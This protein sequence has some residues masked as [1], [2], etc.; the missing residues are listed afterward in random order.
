MDARVFKTKTFARWLRKSGVSDEDLLKA[1]DD[2]EK[3]LVDADL[4]GSVYKK[5]IGINSRGKRGGARTIVATRFESRWFFMFG[6]AKNERAN[7]SPSEKKI[8]QESASELLFL[9][10]AG[11]QILLDN[12]ALV[13][14]EHGS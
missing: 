12:Q 1:V 9:D 4:G 7:I 14:V 13:E 10:D 11:I 3:G 8:F 2:M 6:F 5:R